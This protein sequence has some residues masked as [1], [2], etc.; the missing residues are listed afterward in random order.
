MTMG[1]KLDMLC[2]TLQENSRKIT[3]MWGKQDDMV[4]KN[5]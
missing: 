3:G 5:T 2:M 4:K 1:A